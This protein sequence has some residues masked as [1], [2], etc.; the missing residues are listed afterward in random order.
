M[1][2]QRSGTPSTGKDSEPQL[3]NSPGSTRLL[4]KQQ[5]PEQ[6]SHLANR[7]PTLSGSVDRGRWRYPVPMTDLEPPPEKGDEATTLL[8]AQLIGDGATATTTQPLRVALARLGKEP[9]APV[10]QIGDKTQPTHPQLPCHRQS[11]APPY[12][13]CVLDSAI[14]AWSRILDQCT[15]EIKSLVH[16]LK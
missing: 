13:E 14:Q 6:H 3:Q 12:C 7:Y 4:Q 11:V 15:E 1:S 9:R 16:H 5:P 2:P 8:P 10:S